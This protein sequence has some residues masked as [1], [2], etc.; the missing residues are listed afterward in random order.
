MNRP[1]YP[2]SQYC[3]CH[4]S[5]GGSCPSL[6]LSPTRLPHGWFAGLLLYSRAQCFG[7]LDRLGLN[8]QI[9]GHLHQ[10]SIRHE[11]EL[12]RVLRVALTLLLDDH[13]ESGFSLSE[14][15][16]AGGG[17]R[18]AFPTACFHPALWVLSSFMGDSFMGSR[19]ALP[20]KGLPSLPFNI[21]SKHKGSA[22]PPF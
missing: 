5:R 12:V 21:T 14:R 6:I 19:D 4:L 9:R 22:L 20:A 11:G 17:Q 10:L 13:D 3:L 7:H 8:L 1:L 2:G 16:G 18:A 15:R